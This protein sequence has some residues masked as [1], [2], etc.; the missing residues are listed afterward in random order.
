MNYR[1]LIIFLSSVVCYYTGTFAIFGE[2]TFFSTRS[3]SVN[4][5][6]ELVSWEKEVNQPDKTTCYGTVALAIE[7]NHSFH[8]EDINRFL[9]GSQ[10]LFFSG[11]KAMNRGPNDILADYFGLPFCYRSCV[12]F[13]PVISNTIFDL[14][15]YQGLDCLCCGSGSYLRVHVPVVHAKWDLKLQE[16]VLD[17]GD[18]YSTCGTFTFYPGGYMGPDRIER[19]AMHTNVREAFEGKTSVGDLQPLRFGRIYGRESKT[20][21]AEI[22]IALGRNYFLSDWYHLGLEI[23]TAIPTGNRPEAEF[24]FEPIVGNCHHWELGAGLTG[25]VDFLQ[26]ECHTWA[27]YLDANITHLFA[28][29]Q[30]R[31]YD[32][33]SGPGSRYMTAQLFGDRSTNLV[34]DAAPAEHQY[35]GCIVPV[36]N[37]STLPTDIS[38]AVQGDIALKLAYQ[39][40]DGFECDIGY[41]FWG[42]SK[43]E[44]HCRRRLASDQFVL[45]GD[46]QVYGFEDNGEETPVRMSVSQSEATLHKA[47]AQTNFVPGA[48]FTNENADFPAPAFAANGDVLTQVTLADAADL[49]IAIEQINTSNPTVFLSDADINDCSGLLPRAMTHKLFFHVGRAWHCAEGL[50]PYIGIGGSAE[51]ANTNVRNNS[52]YSQAAIWVKGGFSY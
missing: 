18:N 31:S 17:N 20:R 15:W 36:V 41:N 40:V 12:S 51:W 10:C 43:E 47:Q 11:S 48:E 19:P 28:D 14:N 23:R 24:L 2:R 45:K 1:L 37:I 39:R 46:A 33:K 32:L 9:F 7:Y 30:N 3:Q 50:K 35:I 16:I 8:T 34:V 38:I 5:A 6:L 13:D 29:T 27:L 25:H 4:A 44:S 52:G 26:C 42:R 22:Q 49:Q 21:I